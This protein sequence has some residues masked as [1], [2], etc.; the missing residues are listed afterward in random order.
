MDQFRKWLGSLRF[1]PIGSWRIILLCIL[2][3]TT[4]WFFNALNKTYTTSISQP[5]EFEFDAEG[6]IVVDKLPE[7]VQVNL[8]GGGWNLFRKS[9][10]INTKTIKIPLENPV[11]VRRM[12]ASGLLSILSDELSDFQIN[13]LVSDT[14]RINIQE[15]RKQKFNLEIDTLGIDLAENYRVVSPVRILP[16]TVWIEGPKEILD[17][18]EDPIKLKIDRTRINRNFD[19][20]VEITLSVDRPKVF[21]K[22]PELV[23]VNFQV[24]EF[25]KETLRV[26][27]TP[28]GFPDDWNLSAND[29]LITIK[30]EVG[31]GRRDEIGVPDFNFALRFS[32]INRSDSTVT[33]VGVSYPDFIRLIPPKPVK[34]GKR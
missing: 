14:L 33:P 13:Y 16:D 26:P 25:I 8:T 1:N 20:N 28:V 30:Y 34:I 7:N 9:V 15:L 2:T 6:L 4:F 21:K 24:D 18:I 29:T 23:N 12:V 17:G 11:E 27:A 10:G 19:R 31:K 32:D 3:A 22:D 5:I